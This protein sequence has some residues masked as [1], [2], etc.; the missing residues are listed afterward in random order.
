MGF[1]RAGGAVALAIAVLGLSRPGFT[2]SISDEEP[3]EG[4][5]SGMPSAVSSNSLAGV[6][7]L[8]ALQR[9]AKSNDAAV[10]ARAVARAAQLGS[11]DG[12][13]V[14]EAG[15][16]DNFGDDTDGA[17]RVRLAAVRAL[18]SDPR[19]PSATTALRA[20]FD[21]PEPTSLR[22]PTPYPY[23]GS[24]GPMPPWGP[25]PY[26]PPPPPKPLKHGDPGLV[27]LVRETAALA[28]ALQGEFESLLAHARSPSDVAAQLAARKALLSFPPPSLS[29]LLSKADDKLGKETIE[30]L[31]QLGDLRAADVLVRVAK[32]GALD[33]AGSSEAIRGLA[34]L[35]DG[36][37]VAIAKDVPTDV[38]VRLRVA[39]A[40]ALAELGEPAAA[41]R[42]LALLEKEKTQLDGRNL[43]YEY[44]SKDLVPALAK[45]ASAGDPRAIAAL[46]RVGADAVDVLR[47]LAADDAAKN[48]AADAAAYALATMPGSAAEKAIEGLVEG[49]SPARV[50]RLLR[51]GAV[52]LARMDSAPSKLDAVAKSLVGSKDDADRWVGTLYRCVDSIARCESSLEDADVIVRRAAASALG[53]HPI[54]AAAA[55]ARAH[56]T[57]KA[58]T[59]DALV[60]RGL[61]AVAA[62]AI[63]GSPGRDVPVTTSTLAVWLA[64]DGEASALA[65]YLLAARGG[66]V[67]RPVVERA[68][69]SDDLSVRVAALL[70]LAMAPD[71]TATGDLVGRYPELIT[72]EMRRAAA[73]ALVARRNPGARAVL[74]LARRLDPDADVRALAGGAVLLPSATPTSPLTLGRETLQVKVAAAPGVVARAV[75]V[76]VDGFAAPTLVDPEGVL[77]AFRLPG[78]PT[79]VDVRPVA[80]TNT[81]TNAPTKDATP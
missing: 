67:A 8:A 43:A 64:E 5:S 7:G 1:P 47:S 14:V 28:L 62:R 55:V 23:P 38:D 39:A 37:V 26:M 57:A 29:S 3:E 52:R 68:L 18:A 32:I 59:E 11:D 46:G 69:R 24:I 73:R 71:S 31:A 17:L 15:A 74:E 30:L 49:A 20:V 53:S 66:D 50:R 36:R 19:K 10:R 65:A 58:A 72:A 2:K 27:A 54:A 48:G 78:G 79:R 41:G 56:L 75:V 44:P 63:D 6:L 77:L 51:A 25:G 42:I 81:P 13:K 33:V 12:W 76:R 45:L 34:R 22:P 9:D 21:H 16:A 35:G 80:P 40:A 70:G 4:T 61:V 60:V